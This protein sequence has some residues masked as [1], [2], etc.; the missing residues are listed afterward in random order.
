MKYS[1]KL[2][3]F[4]QKLGYSFHNRELLRTAL[5][6]SSDEKSHLKNYQRLEFLGDRV[7][8]LCITNYFME[9]FPHAK[10]GELA[11]RLNKVV[12]GDTCSEIAKSIALGNV[13]F[14]GDSSRYS[15]IRNRASV[16]SDSLEAIIGAIYLDGGMEPTT[17]TILR[18][19]KHHLDFPLEDAT[20]PKSELQELLHAK[21]SGL[22]EYRLINKL[23]PAHNPEF[24][25][26]VVLES[27]ESAM[28]S[29]SSKKEAE[30]EA[31]K[32]LLQQIEEHHG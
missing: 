2:L 8:A 4:E 15:L 32:L 19:W 7:L 14:V 6:H 31:A 13:L 23:G 27:G 12:S 9:T 29:G 5:T 17:Q 22:P 16:L 28:A 18:L 30:R 1:S 26:E 10:V 3:R 11:S 24:R 20:D 21:R 25:V